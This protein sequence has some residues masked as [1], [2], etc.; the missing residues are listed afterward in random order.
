MN[1]LNQQV[2]LPEDKQNSTLRDHFYRETSKRLGAL[3]A[4]LSDE[5]EFLAVEYSI[6][7][8]M[9]YPYLKPLWAMEV[10]ILMCRPALLSWL[11]RVSQREAIRRLELP[12]Q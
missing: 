1:G 5:R 3:E 2:N 10:P 4:G 7:D 8:I 9:Y 12:S 6:A 11:E